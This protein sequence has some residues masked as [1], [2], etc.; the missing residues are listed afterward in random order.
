MTTQRDVL[1]L[2]F[3]LLLVLR[4]RVYL[5]VGFLGVCRLELKLEKGFLLRDVLKDDLKPLLG[6]EGV[7]LLLLV[8]LVELMRRSNSTVSGLYQDG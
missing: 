5:R 8:R 3:V 4:S 1:Y 2:G 7:C 6:C